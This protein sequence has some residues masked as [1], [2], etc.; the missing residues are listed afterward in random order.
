MNKNF[1]LIGASGYIAP[2]HT[3]AIKKCGGNLLLY[4]DPHDNVGYIDKYFPEAKY[5]KEIERFDRELTRISFSENKIDYVSICSPNYLHDSHMRL[6]LRNGSHIICEKPLVIKYDH[7]EMLQELEKKYDK[8]VYTILQ[9]R[10]LP[11]IISLKEKISE[12]TTKHKVKLNYITPR[13]KWYDYSWKGSIDKSGGLLFNIGIH[14]FDMLIW[15]FGD[16]L[17]FEITT[18][19]SSSRGKLLLE[20]AEVEFFLSVDKDD[21]P[22][23]EWKPFRSITVDE[24]E[25]EFSEGFTE[26]HNKSYTN[27]LGGQGFG[28][29]EVKKTIHLIEKMS[30][31]ER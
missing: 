24:E 29:N 31:N 22:H 1:A 20:K 15:V 12:S 4:T 6:G 10:L 28:I 23:K 13:G 25:L 27:I 18:T 3:E 21:L 26:L 19:S 7:L 8:N 5:F 11:S 30:K 16:P 17:D 9:L 14:F 2:R